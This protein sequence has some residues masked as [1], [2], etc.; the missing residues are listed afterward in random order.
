MSN[1]ERERL[2]RVPAPPRRRPARPGGVGAGTP[3]TPRTGRAFPEAEPLR[4][5]RR[6]G[7]ASM[8]A[9]A[10]PARPEALR[11]GA[12]SR[13]VAWKGP[14]PDV[15]LRSAFSGAETAVLP[16]A[17]AALLRRLAADERG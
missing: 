17:F 10:Q 2:W 8:I 11:D 16:E 15:L 7:E 6:I 9:A 1:R 3:G 14:F 4:A 13:R 12:A 5:A